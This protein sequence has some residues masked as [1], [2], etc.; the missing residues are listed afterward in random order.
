MT[1]VWD[2]DRDLFSENTIHVLAHRFL[3]L[4]R[5]YLSTPD[6]QLAALATAHASSPA[7]SP[8]APID[9]SVDE[10]LDPVRRHDLSRVAVVDGV[11]TL[12][13]GEL[14]REV[15]GVVERLRQAGVS[16][17]MAVAAVLPRGTDTVVTL[18]ACLRI[19]AVYCPFSLDDPSA[20]L[21]ALLERLDP[22]LVVTTRDGALGLPAE[23]L[24]VALVGESGWPAARSGRVIE[25]AAY[26]IH[27][28][29]STGMPKPVVVGRNALAQH[30]TGI[31]G[32]FGLTGEDRVLLFAKP[33]FDV[34]L[35]EVLPSLYAGASLIAPRREVPTAAE[36]VAVLAAR[37]ITVANLPTSYLLAVRAE[38][39]EALRDGRWSPR[40]IVLG[41]E[42]LPVD[43]LRDVLDATD[44]TVLNAY[45]LTEATITS[46]VHEVD[47]AES[48]ALAEVPLG[49]ELPG[50]HIHVLDAGG[51]PLPTGAV[52]ELAVQGVGLAEGYLADEATTAA[53]FVTVP[54]LGGERVY[55]TGDLGY[56]DESGHLCFLGRRDNQ[57][58]LRG[59]RIEP[60]EIEAAASAELG[61]RS[62]AV[63][64]DR[65]GPAGPRLVGFFEGTEVD[66]R[67]LHAALALRLPAALVPAQWVALESMPMLPGGKPNRNMLAALAA[68]HEEPAPEADEAADPQVTLVAEGWREVLGHNRFTA[69]SHFFQVGGHS[70][71]AAQLAAWLEPHLGARP[72]MRMLFQ[73]PVLADQARAVQAVRA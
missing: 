1:L 63:V 18:L 62:C 8:T 69:S 48:A 5:A 6:G 68:A 52:G 55:L 14:D 41:G 65:Q 37:R 15:E 40:L 19:G 60:E 39:G 16:A 50:T 33:S 13:Y 66:G 20:R 42:R 59:Y 12:G 21:A 30:V 38:V 49:T 28:S 4:L 34:A 51:Y 31:A 10:V 36:L 44:A 64:L 2:Y 23:G 45:G 72:P 7:Q 61:G 53:R 11:R 29:G 27:T 9:L 71:L 56:R 35:E 57:L 25:G 47:R 54:A 32:R 46:T 70:L 24:P 43:A 73:N 22:A 58:K 26:V 17:G 3:D 67:A